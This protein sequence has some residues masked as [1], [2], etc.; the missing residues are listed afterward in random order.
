MSVPDVATTEP[1]GPHGA[2]L[3]VLG[4]SLGTSRR[5]WEHAL[6]TLTGSYRVSVWELPGHGASPAERAA[7]SMGELA[8]A[9]AERYEGPFATAGVSIGGAVALELAMRHPDRVFGAVAVC[10]GARLGDP[11]AWTDRAAQVRASG[12]GSLIIPSAQRWFAEGTIAAVPELTGRLL[13]DLRDADDES[14]A[15]CC[16]ALRD[17]DARAGLAATAVPLLAAWGT[18]DP[19]ATEAHAQEIVRAAPHA[20]AARIDGA[21][22]LATVDAPAATATMII[23]F[24]DAAR[25]GAH[26]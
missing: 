6:D 3:L 22:H 26:A 15:R 21:A 9:V 24:L 16:E 7:F 13:H 14:Y 10:S 17:F 20:S 5:V 1:R 4:C 8:D 2:P 11:Q 23:D 12:T 19:V 25:Q 18:L